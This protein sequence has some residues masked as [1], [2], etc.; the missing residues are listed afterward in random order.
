M[1][2][3]R[4]E[5]SSFSWQ[6]LLN[7]WRDMFDKKTIV[8]DLWAGLTVA[9]VA[10]PLNLAL[11][12]AAG[13]DP[14]IGITTGIVAAIVVALFGGQRF[15]ITG[16]AAAM[17]V[18]LVEI[19]RNYG[20]GGV[21]LVGLIAGIMQIAAGAFRLGRFI[22]FI[23][24]PVIVGFANAIG[25][26]VAFNAFDD[27]FGVGKHLKHAHEAAP[28]INHP[29]LPAF[30]RDIYSLIWCLFR[31]AETNPTTVAIGL[32][33]LVIAAGLPRLTKAIPGQ[34]VAIVAA[35]LLTALLNLPI[36]KIGD[37]SYIPNTF[38]LPQLPAL[39]FDQIPV[40]FASAVTVFMLGSI[41]SLL[42][43]TV[44]DGMTGK[45]HNANQE[46]V[47]QG[48][49]NI[50]V[51]FFGG[52]PVT[53]VIARTAVNIRAGAR[54]RLAP[55]THSVVLV[56]LTFFFAKYAEQIPLTALSAI[57]ILTGVRLIEWEQM[58][59]IWKASKAEATISLI[60]TG[61]AL[62][63]DL[64]AGVLVGLM[65]SCGLFIKQ[66][67]LLKLSVLT[68]EDEPGSE[69]L[70]P[71]CKYIEVYS[72]DGP[73]F[74]GAAERFAE[75]I[76]QVE[77]IKVLILRL[78]SVHVMDMTGVE[79]LVSIKK[80]LERKGILLVLTE[81][82]S[83]PLVLLERTGRLKEIGESNIYASFEEALVVNTKRLLKD[84]CKPCL[85]KNSRRKQSCDLAYAL[86][87]SS[88]LAKRLFL[89]DTGNVINLPTDSRLVPV[90]SPLDLPP[91]LIDTPFQILFEQ[92]NF[93]NTNYEVAGLSQLVIG[94]CVDYRKSLDLPKEWAY[95]LRREGANMDGAEFAIALAASKGVKH[96]ALIAHNHCA[97]ANTDIL[98]DDFINTL[99]EEHGWPLDEATKFFDENRRSK[100]INSEIDFVFREAARLSHAFRG[101][102]IVPMMYQLE[103]D[104]LYLLRDWLKL[105]S[106]ASS[107]FIQRG[108]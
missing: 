31:F 10:L 1:S 63:I 88:G 24:M 62:A 29:S 2:N 55:I 77:D 60:T 58:R 32:I 8:S 70:L 81:L 61:A 18:V 28:F 37:I 91:E 65:F 13:V 12:I 7:E 48:L 68:T 90:S 3:N 6:F 95:V 107:K 47:G 21:W 44:A 94:M 4:S 99:V 83:H 78:R 11:A 72:I 59:Q 102:N 41:E 76:V 17:A 40:L 25:I 50:I 51:P 73:L 45:R 52:I 35:T 75:T 66:M 74:F 26:L 56:M 39:P 106:T 96:M 33:A 42:S 80:Q 54:T 27:F 79:T 100:E 15:A 93:G 104:R 71:R 38:Q 86:S 101:L 103:T 89:D 46:L 23:P 64:T 34:L 43:A 36:P 20:I 82:Q 16:P 22:S 84:S 97:M 5:L 30:A 67:S 57:L 49:A 19:V 108:N 69:P 98:R 53:G 14:A 87:T 105:N 9:L 85:D 92:H